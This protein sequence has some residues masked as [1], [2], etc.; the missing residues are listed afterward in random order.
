MLKSKAKWKW[1]EQDDNTSIVDGLLHERGFITDEEKNKFLHPKLEDIQSPADLSAIE[2]AKQRI[3]IAME[4]QEK[5]MVCGDYDADGVTSTALLMTAFM[6]LGVRCDYYI[7]NRFEEGYGLNEPAIRSFADAGYTVIVTVD[8]GIAD[9]HEAQV[10][11]EVGIDL[12]ITDHHEVQATIPDAFAIIHPKLSEK[13]LFKELAGVGVA[14]QFAHYL[15]EYFPEE[16]L[17]FVAIGTIADLV[18]LYE[19]NRIFAY[20]GLRSLTNTLN[21]GIQALKNKCGIADEVTEQ[22]IGF[23]LAPRINAVG[24]LQH[25]TLAVELLLTDDEE[26]AEE[27]AAEMEELNVERQKIVTEIVKEAEQRVHGDNDVIILYDPDWHEGVLGIAASRLVRTFDRPVIML[28]HNLDTN[29]LK[30]SARSIPAF[31]LFENGLQ[32]EHL[33]TNFGGHSQAAGM[34]FPFDHLEAIQTALNAQINEQ[35]R[36]EDFKQEIKISQEMTLGQ[37]TENVVEQINKFAPFGM[38]NKEPMFLVKA[39]PTQ[40][41]Q[42]GQHQNHL[43]LQFTHNQVLI[44]A[45]GFGFGPLAPMLSEHTEI[46]LVGTLQINEWNGNKTVQLMLED[47]AVDHWQLFDYRGRQQVKFF[48]PYLQQYERNL[49]LGDDIVKMK[50]FIGSTDA[51]FVTYET[52]VSLLDKTDILYICDMPRDIDKLQSI[53][54]AVQPDN[55]H[56]SYEVI[57]GAFFQALPTREDF[58][59]LYGYA[60]KFSPIQLKIDLPQIMQTKKWTRDKIIFMLKVFLDLQFITIDHDIMYVNRDADKQ[61]L[62]ESRTYQQQLEQSKIEQ[63]FYYAT[64]EEIKQWFDKNVTASEANEEEIIHGF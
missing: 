32:L 50:T 58:K 54:K 38:G 30:G 56:I 41:R 7:P 20:V 40:V 44:D 14:F 4:Q 59:W 17:E 27:I 57:D 60:L 12:I 15:L 29:E 45:I 13:Y 64:Y 31:N 62:T 53:V 3:F 22:D 46:Q 1:N 23:K 49:F 21:V 5:V 43:K 25:A 2:K 36:E 34:T 28:R 52:D 55:I 8:N 48:T 42:I 19:E 16:L 39:F 35:L 47:I 18:P 10:A 11:K 37:M 51:T 9:V 33:F 61:A 6:E 63:I 26:V 24:R